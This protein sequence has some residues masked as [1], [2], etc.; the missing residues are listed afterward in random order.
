MR[1]TTTALLGIG[2]TGAVAGVRS[3]SR[4]PWRDRAQVRSAG[5]SR[6]RWTALGTSARAEVIAT[7]QELHPTPA[8]RAAARTTLHGP[9]GE[10]LPP[11]HPQHVLA[12]DGRR[13]DACHR[14]AEAETPVDATATDDQR[15]AQETADAGRGGLAFLDE[16]T[17]RLLAEL[18]ETDPRAATHSRGLAVDARARTLREG[19]EHRAEHIAAALVSVVL[20]IL[21]A[22][23]ALAELSEQD[24]G[25]GPEAPR[26]EPPA[27]PPSM[28]ALVRSTL[29]AAPPQGTVSVPSPCCAL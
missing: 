18:G 7:V 20:L 6:A 29:T 17:S 2:P 22:L 26:P 23:A 5:V 4:L 3:W 1:V 13:A 11:D 8:T 24:P 25:T 16:L 28:L 15:A 10:V 12:R 27:P 19:A 21:A 14:R 9:V